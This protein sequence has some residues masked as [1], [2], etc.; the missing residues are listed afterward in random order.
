MKHLFLLAL[1]LVGCPKKPDSEVYFVNLQDSA[2]VPSTFLVKFSVKGMTVVPAGQNIE[3]RKSGHHHILIDNPAGEIPEGQVVP[4][5]A[6][7]IHFGKGQTESVLELSPGKHTLTL[8]FAD[9]AHR[10]YGKKLS[11][12]IT[13]FVSPN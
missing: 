2:K 12:T 10:S 4:M 3:Y 7:N 1:L 8:Q 9:G 13:I 6:K 5:D 11:K